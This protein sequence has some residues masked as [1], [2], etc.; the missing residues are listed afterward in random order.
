MLSDISIKQF[1]LIKI[2][3]INAISKIVWS[4]TLVCSVLYLVP[5]L[6]QMGFNGWVVFNMYTIYLAFYSI[7]CVNQ[8]QP[9]PLI[10]ISLDISAT[11][12]RSNKFLSSLALIC[13]FAVGKNL[14]PLACINNESLVASC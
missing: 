5:I 6:V 1:W 3:Q 11:K 4:V 8:P 9:R 12:N 13:I 7:V 2:L 10:A 14:I